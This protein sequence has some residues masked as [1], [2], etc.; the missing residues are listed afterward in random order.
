MQDLC[1]K[2]ELLWI[3]VQKECNFV[4]LVLLINKNPI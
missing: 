4:V 2:I 3:M 1:G